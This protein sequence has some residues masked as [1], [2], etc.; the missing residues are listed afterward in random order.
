MADSMFTEPVAEHVWKVNYRL[1]EN[2]HFDEPDIRAT[3]SRVALAVSRPEPHHRSNE[4]RDSFEAALSHFRFLPDGRMLAYAGTQRRV[5]LFKCFAAGHL[6]D[7]IDAIFSGLGEAMVAMHAGGAIGCDFSTLRPAGWTAEASGHIAS[8]PLS[9]MQVWDH[10]C[11]ALVS[12]STHPGKMRATLRCDHPDIELFIDAKRDALALRHFN[13]S[14]LVSDEF[15]QAVNEDAP[16]PLMFPLA[17]RPVPP[18]AN[19]CERTWSGATSPEPCLVTRIVAARDLWDRMLRA[20]VECSDPGV[21]FID[22]VEH[23]NNLWYRERI[24]VADLGRGMILPPHGTCNPGAINLTQFI[25][26]PFGPHPKLDLQAIAAAAAVATRMLDNVYE[27]SYFPLKVQEKAARGARRLGLGMTGLADALAML[28][29]RYGSQSSL[30]I[31]DT[32]MQTICHAAYR[33]SI[34]LA[35]ERSAFPEYDATEYL[36]GDFILSLPHDIVESIHANGIRNSHLTAVAPAR[37]TSL[38]ANNISCGIAPIHRFEEVREVK[39]PGGTVKAMP[40]TDYALALFRRLH[41]QNASLPD[42][43]TD[44]RD[45]DPADQLKLYSRVQAHV[46][47]AISTDINFPAQAGVEAC[48]TWAMQ[49]YHLGLK[50]YAVSPVI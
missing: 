27:I 34:G 6:H 41:G 31:A 25:N 3:W 36:A 23:A 28:G 30:E 20:A 14:V 5:T 38:L 43:F 12:T 44:A 18:G 11:S 15:M 24:S 47:Q 49:A 4:W 10:A 39:G 33:T 46:D 40:A 32:L 35:H 37:S 19:L 45:I 8:G 2:G 1:F 9:F 22:R 7:S 50:G 42:Y 29:V 13:L 21:I 26:D 48:R 17:G 16:W